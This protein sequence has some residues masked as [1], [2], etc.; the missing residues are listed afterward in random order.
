MQAGRL[1][2]ISGGGSTMEPTLSSSFIFRRKEEKEEV[3]EERKKKSASFNYFWIRHCR[4][5]MPSRSGLLRSCRRAEAL[6]Q[7]AISRPAPWAV[8]FS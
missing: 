5:S 7:S 4:R 3:E 6:D 2:P 8:A 1:A